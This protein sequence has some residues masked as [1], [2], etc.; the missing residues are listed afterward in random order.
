MDF[1]LASGN[2]HFVWTAGVIAAS[3]FGDRPRP[4]GLYK[5]MLCYD[6]SQELP[7]SV[8]LVQ[9]KQVWLKVIRFLKFSIVPTAR[10]HW[11]FQFPELRMRNDAVNCGYCRDQIYI[12]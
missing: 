3:G 6:S 4:A 1:L 2:T 12:K 10:P 5:L 11:I 9:Y 7:L 8:V